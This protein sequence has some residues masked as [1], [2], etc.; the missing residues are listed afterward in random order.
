M[1]YELTLR[2]SYFGQQTV[3][4]WNYVSTGVEASVSG[5]FGLIDA[6]GAIDTS[7]V[8]PPLK[9]FQLI[10]NCLSSSFAVD[11]IEARACSNYDVEDFY[12]RPFLTPYAG[13]ISATQGMSPT[14]AYGFRTSRVRL[15][16][17][18]GTKRFAGVTE[19]NVDAGGVVIAGMQTLLNAAADAM[20]EVLSFDDEGNIISYAPC[21]VQ[22]ED[23]ITPSGR[24]AYRYY[25]TLAEQLT[26]I[27][28]SI[29]WQ[30]YT[31][32]R[33]QTSRQYGRGV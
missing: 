9:P 3:N 11:T 31:T 10:M 4:R 26:H 1:L 28:T 13:N 18:R 14:Q 6:F 22:K 12:E 16:I 7:G 30:P 5:S 23:Y 29:Q 15:D 27:A 2:G 20:S 8:F 19:G 21:V 33:T 17:D 25:P 32:T 24:K